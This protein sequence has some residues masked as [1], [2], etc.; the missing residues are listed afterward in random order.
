MLWD[1]INRDNLVLWA[2]DKACEDPDERCGEKYEVAWGENR[3]DY[4]VTP[5]GEC[6]P[7]LAKLELGRE[8]KTEEFTR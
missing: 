7:C 2:A 4:K 1:K 5:C 8:L 6:V 3:R